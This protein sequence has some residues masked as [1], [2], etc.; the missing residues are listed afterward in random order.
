MQPVTVSFELQR[1]LGQLDLLNFNGAER[2]RALFAVSLLVA[3]FA[4]LEIVV[5]VEAA[6]KQQLAGKLAADL[7]LRDA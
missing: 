5:Q 2:E 7:V 6:Q 1:V 4:E 3:L